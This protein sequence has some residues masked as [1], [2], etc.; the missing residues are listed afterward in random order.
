MNIIEYILRKEMFFWWVDVMMQEDFKMM[1]SIIFIYKY[2]TFCFLI[3]K[4]L[5]IHE[6][7]LLFFSHLGFYLK[8]K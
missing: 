7:M 1:K 2:L 6:Q 8:K 4:F 3:N 5:M